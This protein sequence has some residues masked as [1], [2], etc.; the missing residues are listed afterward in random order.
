MWR[1]GCPEVGRRVHQQVASKP[2]VQKVYLWR[3]S[4][5]PLGCEAAPCTRSDT[6]YW[7][8]LR[9][10]RSRAGASSLATK[11]LPLEGAQA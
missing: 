8:D 7:Q 1:G 6:P 5:L 4:L 10:L 2:I 11:A 3:G 9:L